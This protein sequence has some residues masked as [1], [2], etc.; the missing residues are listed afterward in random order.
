MLRCYLLNTYKSR[1]FNT[2][3]SRKFR[4]VCFTI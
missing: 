1:T 2:S 3:T 4:D